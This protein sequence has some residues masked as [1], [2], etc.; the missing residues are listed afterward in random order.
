[1]QP[2]CSGIGTSYTIWDPRN[3]TRGGFVTINTAG[4]ASAGLGTKFIQPGQAFFV[5]ASG[6]PVPTVRYRRHI[7]QQVT[8]TGCIVKQRHTE[9][10]SAELFFTEQPSGYRR[11][12]DGAIAIYDNSYSSGADIPMPVK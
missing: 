12:A 5:E 7:K 3:G 6:A 2:A 1:M 11:L 9:S 10:F 4:T 8:I